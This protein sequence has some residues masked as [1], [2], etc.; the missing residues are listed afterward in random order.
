[1]L[2]E[3]LAFNSIERTDMEKTKVLIV[4]DEHAIRRF[5]RTSLSAHGY[6]VYEAANG[7]DAILKSINVRPDLIILEFTRSSDSWAGETTLDSQIVLKI[8]RRLPGV[9]SVPI[10]GLAPADEP[11]VRQR[12]LES[13]AAA[14]LS[15]PLDHQRLLS[16]VR[17]ALEDLTTGSEN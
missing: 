15:R 17:I 10:I 13:G 9:E 4:D 12:A 6:E 11:K 14:C 2:R 5:L 16:A 8:L 1:M 3:Q 7:E